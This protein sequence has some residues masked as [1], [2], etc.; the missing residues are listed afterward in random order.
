M[1]FTCADYWRENLISLVY[2]G[3]LYPL[4]Y[5]AVAR[6]TGQSPLDTRILVLYGL[7]PSALLS[8]MLAVFFDLDSELTSSMFMVSTISFLV[9]VLPMYL[10]FA[11]PSF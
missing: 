7:V 9:F 3:T 6:L 1:A 8:N 5:W 2:R 10:L 11:Q 4:F